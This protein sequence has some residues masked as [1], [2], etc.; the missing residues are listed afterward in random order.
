M[1]DHFWTRWAKEYLNTLI[2]RNK[3]QRPRANLAVGDVVLILDPSLLYRGRWPL[4]KVLEV[5]YGADGKARVASVQT[6]R[7]SFTR[8]VT[9]ICRLPVF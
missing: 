6:Q 4:G 1:R 8:P 7:G 5:T 3:W 2:Q 9:K